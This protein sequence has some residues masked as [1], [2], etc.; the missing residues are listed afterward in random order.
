[1]GEAARGVRIF[2]VDNPT[3]K[4]AGLVLAMAYLGGEK[5]IEKKRAPS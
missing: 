3:P 1:V 5:M 2:R 4:T